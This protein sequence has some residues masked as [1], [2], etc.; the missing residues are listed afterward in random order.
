M[1]NSRGLILRPPKKEAKDG[2]IAGQPISVGVVR[3]KVKVLNTPDEKPVF[4]GEILVT[5]ATDDQ[6]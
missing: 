3:G 2:E 1:I 5:Q 6:S 4:P